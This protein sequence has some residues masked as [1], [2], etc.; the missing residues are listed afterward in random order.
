MNR[1][2]EQQTRFGCMHT[3]THKVEQTIENA[4]ARKRKQSFRIQKPEWFQMCVKGK[5]NV[6]SNKNKDALW[7][8]IVLSFH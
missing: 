5:V 7:L 2:K 3:Q 6:L 1:E 8:L 4:S